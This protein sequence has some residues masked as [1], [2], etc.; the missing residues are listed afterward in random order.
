MRP[1]RLPFARPFGCLLRGLEVFEITVTQ[2]DGDTDGHTG[3]LRYRCG[4]EGENVYA[5]M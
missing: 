4:R 5:L 2:V 3:F 1:A